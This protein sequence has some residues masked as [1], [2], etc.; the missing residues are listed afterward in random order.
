MTN[1]ERYTEWAAVQEYLP[2]TM[3]PWWMEAVCAGKEWDVLL[4]ENEQGEIMGAMP[5]L[6]RKRMGMRFIV[7]PQMASAP[8]KANSACIRLIPIVIG[9]ISDSPAEDTSA[10]S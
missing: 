1:K 5:Y 6:I 4:A 10:G 2:L 3:Q 9:M 7:M 8:L